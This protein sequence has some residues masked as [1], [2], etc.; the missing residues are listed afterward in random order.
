MFTGDIDWS[1]PIQNG[2]T[3]LGFDYFFGISA[4]LDMDPYIYIEND[5]FVGEATTIKDFTSSKT[6]PG[7]AHEDFD[8]ID[9]L[10]EIAARTVDYIESQK[11]HTPFFVYMPLTAPHIPLVPADE[12]KGK[13][14]LGT[15]GD[16]VLQ[17]DHVV[18]QVLDALDRKGFTKE[19]LV[20]F[21][22]DN[23][24]AH[25]VGAAEMEKK[26]HFTN[27]VYRGYK[28]DIFEGGHRIPFIARWPEQV[29]PGTRSD[30]TLCLTDLL[31]TLANITETKLTHFEA[32][33]SVSFLPALL[34]RTLQNPLR[35]AVVHHSGNGTFAIR[36]GKWKLVLDGG[37]GGWSFPTV[38]QAQ[39]EGLPRIQLYNL[40]DDVAETTNVY[41][42]NPEV[43][44]KL[45]ALLLKYKSEGR[46]ITLPRWNYDSIDG[47]L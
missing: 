34:G 13:S 24:G 7:R 31:A 28:A 44:S 42:E 36:Q 15:Y 41:Q 38:A 12:F 19:T 47:N 1:K 11:D 29:E 5:R 21:A 20:I 30:E 22:A 25:Y 26:G 35:E 32:E 27:H 4:S 10:P 16:F 46:S 45:N 23:G 33:D 6:K 14:P 3:A 2:P 40:E 17:V 9:V 8:A 43:V 37:S 18:G 39:L